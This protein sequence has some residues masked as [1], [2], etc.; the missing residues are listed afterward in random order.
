MFYRMFY[1]TCDR[2]LT[3]RMREPISRTSLPCR[4]PIIV[5]LQG[6][7]YDV[8]GGLLSTRPEIRSLAAGAK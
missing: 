6:R 2:S 5:A 7:L 1:F 8:A 3:R 4:F